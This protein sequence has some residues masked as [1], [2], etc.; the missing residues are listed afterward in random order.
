MDPMHGRRNSLL[1]LDVRHEIYGRSLMNL[2][3][4]LSINHSVMCTYQG[5]SHVFES[6]CAPAFSGTFNDKNW[7]CP[8]KKLGVPT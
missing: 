3:Q 6:G 7:V 5:G 2:P 8:R 1:E 4:N